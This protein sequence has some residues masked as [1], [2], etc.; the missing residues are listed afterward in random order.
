V[1]FETTTQIQ[2]QPSH[3]QRLDSVFAASPRA[4][5]VV[6]ARNPLRYLIFNKKMEKEIHS[7]KEMCRKKMLAV[8]TISTWI[9]WIPFF[10][11]CSL[12]WSF[13]TQQFPIENQSNDMFNVSHK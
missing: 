5:H 6:V 9:P 7:P 12:A 4:H 1:I 11:S 13:E 10:S 8:F 2:K 3:L